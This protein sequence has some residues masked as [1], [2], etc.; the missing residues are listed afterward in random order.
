MIEGKEHDKELIDVMYECR[1]GHTQ[2]IR[3]W[4]SETPLP[5]T[6]CVKC[7][8]GFES[9]MSYA[10]MAA[11]GMGMLPNFGSDELVRMVA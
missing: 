1:C 7:C 10:E 2:T 8:A 11:R 9:N 5:A 3:Y 6:N 4:R